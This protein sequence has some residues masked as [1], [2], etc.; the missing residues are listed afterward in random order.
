MKTLKDGALFKVISTIAAEVCTVVLIGALCMSVFLMEKNILSIQDITQK[1]FEDSKFF[2]T[3][4]KDQL[5]E[6]ATYLDNC[7]TI[8]TD[9]EYKEEKEVDVY[10]YALNGR[11]EGEQSDAAHTYKMQDLED[12]SEEQIIQGSSSVH[13]TLTMIGDEIYQ[14]QQLKLLDGEEIVLQKE[15]TEQSQL[16]E[17]VIQHILMQLG[18]YGIYADSLEQAYTMIQAE[19]ND[20]AEQADQGAADTRSEYADTQVDAEYEEMPE[21]STYE[22]EDGSITFMTPEE[23][24][25]EGGTANVSNI[26]DFDAIKSIAEEKEEG[27]DTPGQII[28]TIF[29]YMDV[30]VISMDS[31][32]DLIEEKY[33]PIDGK[34]IAARLRD[35]TISI[36][37]AQTWYERLNR[38]LAEIP[39]KFK[40][41][42]QVRN[43]LDGG[44]SNIYYYFYSKESAKSNIAENQLGDKSKETL[45][46]LG[47]QYG[48]YLYYNSSNAVLD[49]NV[50]GMDDYFYE[51]H[52]INKNTLS[53]RSITFFM[54]FDMK[55]PH[56]DSLLQARKDFYHYQPMIRGCLI[57][58]IAA[59]VGWIVSMVCVTVSSGRVRGR[60]TPVTYWIDKVYGEIMVILEIILI[61][62]CFAVPLWIVNAWYDVNGGTF[63][64]I[65]SCA[66]GFVGMSGTLIFYTSLVRRIKSETVLSQTICGLL[67]RVARKSY[68]H[69]KVTG[70]IVI[71]F[72]IHLIV[73]L[74]L[75]LLI[76]D[77]GGELFF[78]TLLVLFCIFECFILVRDAVQ[79]QR[80]EES[81]NKISNGDLE[82]K[83]DVN[84]LT[85]INKGIGSAIN[86]IGDGLYRA[87]DA[88]M[89]N[90]RLK[91]DLI[92]NVSH[93]IKTPLTSIINYVDLLQREEIENEKVQEYLQILATKSQRLKQLTED[94]VEASKVS[95]GNIKLQFER[96][97]I[98]ELL[99]QTSG[100]FEDKFAKADLTEIKKYPQQPV[101]IWA[102]GRSLFRV[103]ENIYNNAAKYA[104]PHTR[105]YVD[106][107]VN[108][109]Q[110]ILS[111]KNVSQQ[112]LN[113]KA[114]ELTERFIRGDISRSTEGS[115]LGLSIASNLT[116]LMHG[117]FD[118]YLDGDLFKVTI[119]FP[120]ADSIRNGEAWIEEASIGSLGSQDFG[121]RKEDADKNGQKKKK[122]YYVNF[123]IR[124]TLKNPFHKGKK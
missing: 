116:E 71:L 110:V 10:E 124:N 86:N 99:N 16:G 31:S 90:E 77:G 5:Q 114:E 47:E 43:S 14:V 13:T 22:I 49:T 98:V 17:L 104:M 1:S 79:R 41:Y 54:A 97:N 48:S 70:K 30:A 56:E 108:G 40:D 27:A 92:T 24:Q 94:L 113:I 69:R 2:Q 83:V 121:S 32:V 63:F 102:D 7:R 93:D 74:V 73:C 61:V 9:G 39:E 85:G 33:L 51:S 3:F 4:W 66:S 118:I 45:T 55:M 82:H 58:A 52:S 18:N 21:S 87:V 37:E 111:V 122:K 46:K 112:E 59:L 20:E 11:A 42:Q 75:V 6:V 72:T 34:G 120:L 84:G 29:R 100:E 50:P 91:A 62:M 106:M 12:W 67:I 95:S 123:H 60:E 38:A 115:G 76:A 103:M 117:K 44:K 89:K 107:I 81:I 26:N 78:G 88:S 19:A 96:I 109:D 15:I 57:L 101:V 28:P 65:A 119:S 35:G 23:V 80:L 68:E 64:I 36:S 105:V 8:E 25:E 53:G